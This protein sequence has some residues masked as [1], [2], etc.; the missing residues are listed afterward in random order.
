M[1]AHPHNFSALPALQNNQKRL[2]LCPGAE[3]G[4]AKQWPTERYAGVAQ[5]LLSENWQIVLLGSEADRQTGQEIVNQINTHSRENII[6]LC[7][8][9]QLNEAID[10]LDSADIVISNDSGLMHIAS[11]LQK[12]LIAIYGPTSPDFTPPL[13]PDANIVQIDVECGPCFQRECP[14]KHHQCMQQI[15]SERVLALIKDSYHIESSYEQPV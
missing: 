12:P 5:A 3:F 8:E 14:E 4:P 1:V 15:S 6:N 9:T 13:A 11:A 7:G 10:I 2:I